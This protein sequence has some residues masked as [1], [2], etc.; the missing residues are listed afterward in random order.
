MNQ[1]P[2]R[3]S[4]YINTKAQTRVHTN[5]LCGETSQW[6]HKESET[7]VMFHITMGIFL[8]INHAKIISQLLSGKIR[9]QATRKHSR[10]HKGRWLMNS[11]MQ[12]A[13]NL[14]LRLSMQIIYVG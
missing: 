10:N 7:T 1:G 13:D 9:H 12:R 8:I 11:F 14:V 5:C 2:Y 4:T 6:I 3:Q